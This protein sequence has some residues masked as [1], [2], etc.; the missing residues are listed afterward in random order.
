MLNEKAQFT[1]P[2]T[3]IDPQTGAADTHIEIDVY[4]FG[5]TILRWAFVGTGTSGANFTD[6]TPDL[7]LLAASTPSQVVDTTTGI[8]RFNN[9]QPFPI[10][11]RIR[12][13]TTNGLMAKQ[14]N[15][16]WIIAAQGGDTFNVAITQG[17]EVIIDGHT[18]HVYQVVNA[19]SIELAEDPTGTLVDTGTYPWEIPAGTLLNGQPCPHIWGPYGTGV[20]GSVI[21]GCGAANA[22]GTLF[23]TNGND[24]DASDIANSL[25]V[26]SPSEPLRGGCVYNGTA[27]V[28]S[29]ERMF[30]IF[31]SLSTGNQFYVQEVVGGRGLWMEWSLTVQTNSIAD[32][33]ISWVGKDG[34]YDWSPQHGCRS[35]T[36]DTL[37]PWF[38]HDN[39]QPATL[40]Q[41]FPGPLMVSE[42]FSPPDF[43][44]GSNLPTSH[45][46]GHRLCWIDGELFYDFIN[47]SGTCATLV[48][49]AKQAQGWVSVDL[50][51]NVSGQLVSR[52]TEIAGNNMKISIGG[53]IYDYATMI[54]ASTTDAGTA[55]ACRVVT[56]ADDAGDLRAQK[57]YG[58]IF[59][60]ANPNSVTVTANI[61][62]ALH[63]VTEISPTVNQATR[64]AG[65]L[66]LSS[67]GLGILTNTLGLDITWTGAGVVLFQW[68]YSFVPKPEFQG[69]RALDKTDDGWLGT[70]YL[71]GFVIEVNTGNQARLCNVLVDGVKQINPITSTTIFS[72]N[73]G[74]NT[75]AEIPLAVTPA[76]GLPSVLGQEFQIAI[77]ATDSSTVGWE[78]FSIRWVWEKWIDLDIKSSPVLNLG[79]NKIKEIRSLVLPLDTNTGAVTI[80][81]QFDSGASVGTYALPATTTT[82]GKKTPVAFALIPP[83]VAHTLQFVPNAACRAWYDE[84]AFSATEW[85]ERI[86]EESMWIAPAG[87]SKPAYIR[88]FSIP[89]ETGGSSIGFTL[90]FDDNTSVALGAATTTALIKT[91]VP[92]ALAIPK[93]SHQVRIEPGPARCW[94]DEIVWDAEEYPEL[95]VE[96][97]A[98]VDCGYER[99][100]FMQGVVIPIDTNG[101]PVQFQFINIDT[102]GVYT[103]PAY[104]ATGKQAQAFSWPPFIAHHIQ[105]LPSGPARIFLAEASWVFEP[106]PELALTWTTPAMTHGL[107]GWLHQRLAWMAYLS[108]QTVTFTRTFSDGSSETYSLPSTAGAYRKTLLPLVPK[109]SMW[110]QY[111]MTSPAV[112]K[113]FVNDIELHTKQWGSQGPYT[114]QRPI[115]APS[116][117][118]GADI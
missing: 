14:S 5:G 83:V 33:S 19:A 66:D 36:D 116:V 56:R 90:H 44:I 107:T 39:Q 57:L 11:D 96:Y 54:G 108:T 47:V 82:A 41:I 15:G 4:R 53:T 93:V 114:I 117:V 110:Y 48:Y 98:I 91:T 89:I 79:T 115:G 104:I 68:Q 88:G 8:S 72:I 87:S 71:R 76:G 55:I 49:D 38:P 86:S 43:F 42:A 80:T 70:K 94:W 92:F 69:L 30:Q 6:N 31:P 2:S 105:I 37:F 74:T 18:F 21:F 73:S 3:P 109:K 20:Q 59:F 118:Q 27:Y 50:Y 9:F 17:S 63:T 23:W 1:L 7:Q 113:V 12:T 84:I 10:P 13:S 95:N 25:V 77:D 102:G 16:T 28:W 85:P 103:S 97:T 24:P 64:T 61:L 46:A 112:F 62:G 51:K 40:V 75:Q 65:Y 35:L 81:I 52:M 58:D 32:Q 45:A 29:T 106:T 111:S 78:V 22:A 67:S 26:T 99:A 100:K 101:A 34:V 60:D